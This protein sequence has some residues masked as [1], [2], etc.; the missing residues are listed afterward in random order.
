MTTFKYYSFDIAVMFEGED[1]N[2]MFDGIVALSAEDAAKDV[3]NAYGTPCKLMSNMKQVFV[4][5]IT[6]K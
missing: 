2:R 1:I 5:E 6:Y 4:K 3:E